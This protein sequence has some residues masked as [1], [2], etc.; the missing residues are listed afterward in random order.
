MMADLPAV[1]MSDIVRQDPL[2]KAKMK[3][4]QVNERK[5][6]INGLKQKLKDLRNVEQ[7][8]IELQIETLE[9]EIG[10]LESVEVEGKNK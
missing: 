10:I 4:I 3:K 5:S 6:W 8:K 1:P 7:K 2:L 9:I